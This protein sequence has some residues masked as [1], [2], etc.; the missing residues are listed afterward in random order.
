MLNITLP[1][2]SRNSVCKEVSGSD[3]LTPNGWYLL[4]GWAIRYDP[5]PNVKPGKG[6]SGTYRGSRRKTLRVPARRNLSHG[7]NRQRMT[8]CLDGKISPTLHR[9]DR[10]S[11]TLT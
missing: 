6:R 2:E 10:R 11:A 9:L 8:A 7:P 5:S 4:R 3:D 1:D